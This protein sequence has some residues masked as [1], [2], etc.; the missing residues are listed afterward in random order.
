MSL[1]LPVGKEVDVKWVGA[2]T[3][4][5]PQGQSQGCG[6]SHCLIL[7]CVLQKPE[8][9]IMELSMH[10]HTT[11]ETLEEDPGE[12]AAVTD[13]PVFH[14]NTVIQQLK[15]N[16]YGLQKGYCFIATLHVSQE[17]LLWL[18]LPRNRQEWM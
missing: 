1:E 9:L 14:T 8:P 15:D 18:I 3:G 4:W 6:S 13:L 11:H 7:M 17:N 10:T 5:R 12:G 16:T 2:R